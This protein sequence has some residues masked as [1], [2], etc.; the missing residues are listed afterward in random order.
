[1]SELLQLAIV[2]EDKNLMIVWKLEL[3]VW[4]MCIIFRKS[5]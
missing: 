4:S 5:R 1:M 3:S 2:R